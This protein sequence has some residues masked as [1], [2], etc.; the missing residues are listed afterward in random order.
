MES[1]DG[2][3]RGSV[4]DCLKCRI[5]SRGYVVDEGYSHQ[6]DQIRQLGRCS[7]GFRHPLVRRMC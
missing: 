4:D 3:N 5:S 1:C 7:L 2:L 6:G